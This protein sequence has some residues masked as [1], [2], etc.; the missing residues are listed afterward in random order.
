MM[1]FKIVS[2]SQKTYRR[3]MK[4]FINYGLFIFVYRK[5]AVTE[6]VHSFFICNG[7]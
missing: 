3:R 5:T 2:V 1:I 6:D 4:Q 7:K